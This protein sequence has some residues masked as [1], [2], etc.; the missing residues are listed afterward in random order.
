VPLVVGSLL[1]PAAI[2]AGAAGNGTPV[3][4]GGV[5]GPLQDGAAGLFSNP[6]AA[7]PAEGEL[8]F[9][10]QYAHSSVEMQLSGQE[11]E[12]DAGGSVIPAL[13]VASPPL[14]PVGLGLALHVP[15]GRGGENPEDSTLRFHNQSGEIRAMEAALNVAVQPADW[16]TVGVA[17]RAA[18]LTLATVNATDTGA[19]L[20][21][22]LDQGGEELLN[23]PFLEGTQ[24][25]S[26]KGLAGGWAAGVRVTPPGGWVFAA[27]FRS[28]LRGVVEGDLSYV[29][30]NQLAVEITGN[31]ETYLEFPAELSVGAALPVGRVT[32]TPELTWIGWSS[33]NRIETRLH[34][35]SFGSRD[36]YLDA[37]IEALGGSLDTLIADMDS[38]VTTNGTSDIFSG[39]V[40]VKAQVADAWD[41][42]GGVYL[43][44]AATQDDHVHPGNVDFAVADVRAG[45]VYWTQRRTRFAV[46]A[47]R[48]FAP[49][50]SVS[51]S[52]Y[53]PLAD[54][55][56]GLAVPSGDGRYSLALWRAGLTVIQ[57]FGPHP[58]GG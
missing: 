54:P 26:G 19:M 41:L 50:R 5:A 44:P 56:T 22:L 21:G 25:V 57:P 35:L 10:L 20:A 12:A 18:Q 39:G 27:D 14:G 46:T 43:T 13:S 9:D 38:N 53:D 2:A 34:D 31:Q 30:S 6:A 48:M 45:A 40:G 24:S 3:L 52:V 36:P 42:L 1:L 11:A 4:G 32:I 28:K 16:L 55:E 49:E 47:D 17:G 29:L 37:Y 23:D 7:H 58:S 33:W 51:Q 8:L 15:Y